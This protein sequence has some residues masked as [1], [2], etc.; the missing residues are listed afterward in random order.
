[1]GCEPFYAPGGR[2]SAIVCSRGRGGSRRTS[3]CAKCGKEGALLCDGPSSRQGKT[4]DAPL[5]SDCAISIRYVDA[6]FCPEHGSEAAGPCACGP[7]GV[8]CLGVLVEKVGGL[9]L[10]HAVLFDYWLGYAGGF[11]TYRRMDLTR[12]EKR[13]EFRRWL[14][15]MKPEG[16]DLILVARHVR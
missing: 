16:L 6:D 8:P 12:S 15:G 5:C 14:A 10:S 13:E 2:I 11:P 7:A 9:C 1:M 3:P 4:C